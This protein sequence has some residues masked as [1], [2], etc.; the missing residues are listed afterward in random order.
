MNADL[1]LAKHFFP[2]EEAGRYAVVAMVGRII[3]FLPQP[4]V[5]AMF[6]KVVSSG[7]ISRTDW[8][9]LTKAL[10]LAGLLL[11]GTATICS[12]FAETVLAGF[13]GTRSADLVP[14]VQLMV[15]GLCPLSLTFFILNFELAQRRFAVAVPL[16]AC[17]AGYLACLA[18]W[19]DTMQQVVLILAIAGT[20]AFVSS[21]AC[22]PWRRLGQGEAPGRA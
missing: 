21:V 3:L 16:L 5:M 17:A 11:A 4:I 8:R 12:V 7:E 1:V 20:A 18:R 22:L 14:L 6:P 10:V 15:W 9:M 19:H 13:T 2:A